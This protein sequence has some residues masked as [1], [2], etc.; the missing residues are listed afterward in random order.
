VQRFPRASFAATIV[1][2]ASAFSVIK[3]LIDHGIGAEQIA[4]SPLPLSPRPAL[5]SFSGARAGCRD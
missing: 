3:A 5:P 4:L 2:W 1:V